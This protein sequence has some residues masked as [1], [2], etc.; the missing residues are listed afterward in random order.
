MTSLKIKQIKKQF[1]ADYYYLL[2]FLY[3]FSI[4][5]YFLMYLSNSYF[6]TYKYNIIFFNFHFFN[7]SFAYNIIINLLIIFILI[8]LKW[9]LY[10]NTSKSFEFL[11]GLI[12]FFTC[13]QYYLILNNLIALIM[14]FEF[15]S[16]TF[17]YLLANNFN[18]NSNYK[19]TY[20]LRYNNFTN[21]PI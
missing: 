9:N 6:F 11:I 19:L 4:Y 3:N 17:I 5:N 1:I 14:L 16:L 20:T 13:T 7:Y 8:I 21:Q 12:F 15:Q 2:K 10:Q 18:I